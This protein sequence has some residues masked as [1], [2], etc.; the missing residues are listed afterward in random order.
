MLKFI[1]KIKKSVKS[2]QI[3]RKSPFRFASFPPMVRLQLIKIYN[4]RQFNCLRKERDE[5]NIHERKYNIYI[6]LAV[7]YN[8]M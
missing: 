2:I 1:C 3:E 7:W 5:I 8:D 4:L 6:F